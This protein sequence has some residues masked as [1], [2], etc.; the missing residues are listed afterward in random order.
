MYFFKYKNMLLMISCLPLLTG[1]QTIATSSVESQTSEE[2]GL[3]DQ[4]VEEEFVIREPTIQDSESNTEVELDSEEY[5]FGKVHL[6]KEDINFAVKKF[7]VSE[8]SSFTY[9]VDVSLTSN[10]HELS[11]SS[12]TEAYNIST[13][14]LRIIDEEGNELLGEN[15]NIQVMAASGV[16]TAIISKDLADETTNESFI[17]Y[18]FSI[19]D[20]NKIKVEFV[21]DDGKV[22]YSSDWIERES[23]DLSQIF[24]EYAH[25]EAFITENGKQPKDIPLS[26]IEPAMFTQISM[27]HVIESCS[28]A[29]GVYTRSIAYGLG[30]DGKIY[31]WSPQYNTLDSWDSWV[32][33]EEMT[34]DA[35]NFDYTPW[36]W[37]PG[38]KEDVL[39]ECI[40]LGYIKEGEY[41]IHPKYV[42]R[43]EGYYGIYV[44]YENSLVQVIYVNCKTGYFH[45]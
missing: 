37:A 8:Q 28:Y 2:V 32:Y 4:N 30:T 17:T 1:C 41:Y 3:E 33:E 36:E 38:V 39:Q 20:S 34:A 15:G 16:D 22:M 44:E 19:P 11:S 26:P 35:M 24:T 5:K 45:G 40:D 18:H 21:D 23:T 43:G 14:N 7:T 31:S 29:E 12:K 27:Q 13:A 25:F 6:T 9:K 42:E 10:V